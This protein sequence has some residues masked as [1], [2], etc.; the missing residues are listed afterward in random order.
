MKMWE[1]VLKGEV[2]Q[3]VTS[4]EHIITSV[5]QHGALPFGGS[6]AP[7]DASGDFVL[8]ERKSHTAIYN[9]VVKIA[10]EYTGAWAFRRDDKGVAV[11]GPPGIGNSCSLNLVFL[12]CAAI[13]EVT[14]HEGFGRRRTFKRRKPVIV[15]DR[16][17]NTE[18]GRYLIFTPGPDPKVEVSSV[19][20][21]ALNDRENIYLYEPPKGS[22]SRDKHFHACS[23]AFYVVA[24]NPNQHSWKAVRYSA[25]MHY[26]YR[27]EPEEAEEVQKAL[28][29]QADPTVVERCGFSLRLLTTGQEGAVTA[30]Q[31]VENALDAVG[32]HYDLHDMAF[33]FKFQV[34]SQLT[35][36]LALLT[37]KPTKY[38]EPDSY[39]I[40]PVSDYVRQRL[41]SKLGTQCPDDDFDMIVD[42]FDCHYRQQLFRSQECDT[43]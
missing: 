23:M 17:V 12:R 39:D 1:S 24:S 20:P 31:R 33:E 26:A 40:C 32:S 30:M 6:S 15:C 18:D 4:Y 19:Y 2:K 34:R 41:R 3:D 14:V 13:K 38:E 11:V 42:L 27:W 35:H 29:V 7:K 25:L 22:V 37:M 8:I 5:F 10:E 9:E 16:A 36:P 43:C 28:G 21:D